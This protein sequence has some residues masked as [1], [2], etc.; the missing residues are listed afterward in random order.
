MGLDVNLNSAALSIGT[1]ATL[2]VS[3]CIGWKLARLREK[4]T[5]NWA[6]SAIVP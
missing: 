5:G 3:I 4:E 2:A 1:L 6:H